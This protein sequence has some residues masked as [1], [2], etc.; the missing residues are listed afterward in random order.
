VIGRAVENQQDVL[1]GK[2]ACQH[3]EEGLEAAVFE[4]GMIK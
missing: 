1:P 3:I 4:V 2:P